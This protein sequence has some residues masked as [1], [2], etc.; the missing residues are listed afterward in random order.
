MFTLIFYNQKAVILRLVKTPN[1]MIKQIFK[2]VTLVILFAT[3]AGNLSAQTCDTCTWHITGNNATSYTVSTGQTLCIDSSGIA[4]GTI[5]LQGGT[6]CNH[7]TIDVSSITLTSGTVYNFNKL[8][9]GQ[10]LTINA[11]ILFE[12]IENGHT[13]ITGDLIFYAKKM[14]NEGTIVITNDIELQTG[15]LI[16]FGHIKCHQFHRLSGE[17]LNHAFL[18]ETNTIPN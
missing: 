17:F 12:N 1:K 9:I 10:D 3:I 6:I 4:T 16:N 14:Y 13:K 7:G 18:S 2:K 11:D 5:L 8:I 15:L